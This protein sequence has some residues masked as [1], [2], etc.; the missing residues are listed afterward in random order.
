MTAIAERRTRRTVVGAVVA[1]LLIVAASAM[2]VVGVVTLSNSQEGEAVGVDT[3]P[4]VQ[5]PA[6]P[7][8]LLAVTDENGQLA[9]VVVMTLL[10]EGQGGSIVTVPV[11]ADSSAGFG[12]QRR[13]LDESFDADDV[14][15]LVASVEEMLAIT[16][17]RAAIVDAEGLEALLP[18]VEALQI[19]VPNDVVDTQGGGGVISTAGP[20]TFTVDEMV[21]ILTAVDD[22]AEV[23]TSHAN[24]VAVWESLAQTAPVAVPPEQVPLDELGRPV[25]PAT[26]DELMTRLWQGE[27]TVR[28]LLVVPV[29]EESNPTEADVVLI[30]RRDSNLVFAQVSPGLVSTPNTGLTVRIVANYTDDQ[31]AEADGAYG[32]SSDLVVE[33]IGR[34][35]FLGGNVT[36]VDTAPTG[37]PPVTIIE[38]AD[39]RQLQESIEAAEALFGEAEVRVSESIIEGIDVEVILGLSYLEREAERFG[40]VAPDTVP[41]ESTDVAGTVPEDG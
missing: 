14:E 41:T 31:L 15:S 25:A 28:D 29:E 22:D 32:S 40:D 39:E 13:P 30:D 24:D 6:T 2:F 36:S 17:Q 35:L 38:V 7:N 1:M 37:A 8:A 11:N 26:V 33:M 18:D 19:V 5:F 12:L 9:S 21:S 20:Q 3:R 10:P 23:D 34:L 4:R 16:L 27:I